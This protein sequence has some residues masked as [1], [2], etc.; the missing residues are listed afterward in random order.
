LCE[1]VHISITISSPSSAIGDGDAV[2]VAR[3]VAQHLLGL[4]ERLAANE[5][6]ELIINMKTA[7]ALGLTFPP[8]LL[9]RA[10]AVIE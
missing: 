2:G 7:K 4:G 5:N 1:A 3:Q 10:D 9:G 6:I 8:T